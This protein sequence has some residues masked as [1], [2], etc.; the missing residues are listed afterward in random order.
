MSYAAVAGEAA[1]NNDLIVSLN[2]KTVNIRDR[3]RRAWIESA[4]VTSI[5]IQAGQTRNG[6][7]IELVEHTFDDHFVAALLDGVN[8]DGDGGIG[9]IVESRA[10]IVAGVERAIAIETSD[11]RTRHTARIA[12]NDVK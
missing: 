11:A 10:W 5:G 2:E 9:R 6:I 8:S 12:G 4:V 1:K 3:S 7:A